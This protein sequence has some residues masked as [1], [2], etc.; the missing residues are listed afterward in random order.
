[1]DKFSAQRQIRSLADDISGSK[2]NVT[3]GGNLVHDTNGILI[4]SCDSALP[5]GSAIT[6][7][8]MG[9]TGSTFSA[10]LVIG[11]SNEPHS[12]VLPI[13]IMGV[14]ANASSL[15]ANRGIV[16]LY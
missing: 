9:A 14:T 8:L 6:V 11:N 5:G 1:M 12:Q 3:G 2:A 7:H 15:G 4:Y 13:K 16:G 10:D